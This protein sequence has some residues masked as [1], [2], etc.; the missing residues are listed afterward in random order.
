MIVSPST[1][2]PALGSNHMPGHSSLY[3]KFRIFPLGASFRSINSPS[4]FAKRLRSHSDFYYASKY[5][6]YREPINSANSNKALGTEGQ[7]TIYK[8]LTTNEKFVVDGAMEYANRGD[9][10]NAI[11]SYI[12][13]ASK[14]GTVSPLSKTILEA[15]TEN[16]AKF[17]EGLLGFYHHKA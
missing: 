11:A 6:F 7:D 13:E 4:P 16:A 12:S 3:F 5:I 15:Y 2:A 8:N 10:P 9:F 1:N 17:R 14:I